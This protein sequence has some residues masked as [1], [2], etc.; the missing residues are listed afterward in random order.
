MKK[1]VLSLLIIATFSLYGCGDSPAEDQSNITTQSFIGQLEVLSA[2]VSGLDV[3]HVL[4]TEAKERIYLRSLILDLTDYEDQKVRLFGELVEEEVAGNPVKVITVSSLDSLDSSN[5]SD[6][7]L[8]SFS[9]KEMGLNFKFDDSKF[10][11][12]QSNT[13]IILTSMESSGAIFIKLMKSNPELDFDLYLSQNYSTSDFAKFS[14]GR[15]SGLSNEESNNKKLVYLFENDEFFYELSY[16]GDNELSKEDKITLVSDLISSISFTEVVN[17]AFKL[18]LEK[19]DESGTS[20]SSSDSSS[21]S[22]TSES[23]QV[24]S[25]YAPVISGFEAKVSGLLPKFKSA[26][27]YSFTDN[28]YFY[29]VYMD[30][31]STRFRAL[32]KY[33][34]NNFEIIAEFERGTNVDWNLVSG[35]NIAYDRAQDLVIVSDSGPVREVKVEK[36]YR[37]FES[38]PLGFGIQYP[39]NWYY[40]R[41]EDAYIFSNEPLESSNVKVRAELLKVSYDSVDGS[42]IKPGL[43]RSTSGGNTVYNAKVGNYVLR[44]TGSPEFSQQLE[45]MASSVSELNFD[46]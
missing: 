6:A 21:G 12:D 29:V 15:V 45:L 23:S 2:S 39:Q 16:I 44:L 13:R 25:K 4:V 5:E 40:S 20:E 11:L 36:G 8:S 7:N 41:V 42:Q 37:Y 43:K 38:L 24:S 22:N 34:S 18:E 17:D 35:A 19:V 32:V 10:E 26:A 46:N 30:A 1:T 33:S 9:S 28:G 31:D 14:L 27:S 3:T